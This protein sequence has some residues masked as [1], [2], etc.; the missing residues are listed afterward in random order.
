MSVSKKS[1]HSFDTTEALLA[2]VKA[3]EC[4]LAYAEALQ[5]RDQAQNE[6]VVAY[7]LYKGVPEFM[8]G[9]RGSQQ[10]YEYGRYIERGTADWDSMMVA[11]AP[12]YAALQK[13]KA[14]ARRLHA[15]LLKLASQA[16]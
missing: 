3:G 16:A 6:L 15:K 14:K 8:A 11:T 2:V 1:M 13:A 4:A 9:L 5:A 7:D 12:Q 10:F